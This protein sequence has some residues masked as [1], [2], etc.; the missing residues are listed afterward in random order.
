VPRILHVRRP[1]QLNIRQQSIG[2]RCDRRKLGMILADAL[3]RKQLDVE[4]VSGTHFTNQN[5]VIDRAN[6][7][8]RVNGCLIANRYPLDLPRVDAMVLVHVLV[9]GHLS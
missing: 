3:H 9:I 5:I 1:V 8:F 4:L 6:C 2:N 7:R